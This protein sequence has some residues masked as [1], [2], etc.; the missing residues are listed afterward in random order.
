MVSL[1]FPAPR[2]KTE[3]LVNLAYQISS[4]GLIA[5][6]VNLVYERLQNVHSNYIPVELIWY[7]RFTRPSVFSQG[8]GNARLS[9][10][11]IVQYNLCRRTL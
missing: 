11:M 6:V 4:T 7:A 1:A 10:I 8:A 2:E 5:P 9:R 3:G